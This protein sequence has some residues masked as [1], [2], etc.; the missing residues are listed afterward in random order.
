MKVIKSFVFF[1]FMLLLIVACEEKPES[2]AGTEM[3]TAEIPNVDEDMT[4]WRDAWNANDAQSLKD[5]A[6]DDAVLL[7][8]GRKLSGDSLN[9]WMDST[10]F[11]M[12]DL[13]T[14]ALLKGNENNLAWESGTYV[15]G[16][17]RNDT[18]SMSGTYTIIWERAEGED[19]GAWQVRVMDIS[20]E[21][22]PLQPSQ[23]RQ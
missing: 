1:T 16:S 4:G 9:T 20:P 11:W 2:T 15:H 10:A 14:T 13:R 19:N 7:M 8:W 22:Q 12:R 5:Y 17:T 18:L 23:Q 21:Q 6:A 3:E